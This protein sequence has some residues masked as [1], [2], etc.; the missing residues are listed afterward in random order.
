MPLRKALILFFVVVAVVYG[1]LL[2]P[3]PGVL[4]GY[5]AAVAGTGNIFFRRIGNGLVTFETM[6]SPTPDKDTEVVLKNVSTGSTGKININ[7][8]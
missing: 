1:V 5:R 6:G 2:V 7:S 3:L 4:P 8:V